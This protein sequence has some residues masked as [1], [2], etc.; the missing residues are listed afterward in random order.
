MAKPAVMAVVVRVPPGTVPSST[1]LSVLP[2]ASNAPT[3]ST[4]L[5]RSCIVLILS[6]SSLVRS[7]AASSLLMPH[8]W[9]KLSR[10]SLCRQLSIP[11]S[12]MSHVGRSVVS[13]ISSVSSNETACT[14]PERF[15]P[16]APAF[17]TYSVQQ[18]CNIYI[19]IYTQILH[20]KIAF[21]LYGERT[22]NKSRSRSISF[23]G[24]LGRCS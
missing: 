8:R 4:R 14:S 24:Y 11:A 12:A 3:D 7:V 1:L 23:D 21:A 13:S 15:P 19:D 16:D 17:C 6:D 2:R 9:M 18:I 22:A 10:S 5:S 20:E